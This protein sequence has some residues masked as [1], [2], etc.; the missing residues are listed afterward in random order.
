METSAEF[1]VPE[2]LQGYKALGFDMDH[3]MVNYKLDAFFEM[4][5]LMLLEGMAEQ[6]MLNESEIDFDFQ[7]EMLPYIEKYLVLDTTNGYVLKIG[8]DRKIIKVLFGQE[9]LSDERIAEVYG[10]ERQLPELCEK[11]QWPKRYVDFPSYFEA[12]FLPPMLKLIHE[13]KNNPEFHV[14]ETFSNMGKIAH[15]S[16]V[17]VLTEDLPKSRYFRYIMEEPDKYVVDHRARKEWLQK[18]REQGYKIFLVTN[19]RVGYVKLI[20]EASFGPDWDS[21]FDFV[22]LDA[23]KPEFFEKTNKA[24]KVDGEQTADVVEEGN[25]DGEQTADVVEEGNLDGEQTADV[26]EEGNLDG[27]QTADVV[28]EGNLDGEQTADVVEEGNLDGEQTADVVEEGNLELGKKYVRG[29][30]A[31]VNKA[32]GVSDRDVLFFGDQYIT[33]IAAAKQL[34]G[35]DTC[36]ICEE[37]GYLVDESKVTIPQGLG[38]KWG[39]H[40]RGEDGRE[41]FWFT[42]LRKHATHILPTI[43]TAL[44]ASTAE[45]YFKAFKAEFKDQ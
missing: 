10:E 44:D 24:H 34:A 5:I 23:R 8:P 6:Q 45:E 22:F 3:C 21:V 43:D 1:K 37:L 31:D 41:N 27:E 20:M 2:F 15:E 36:G 4:S 9:E 29:S 32:L 35:W 28:E 30:Y 26:V 7:R 38:A 40:L 11:N 12:C 19:S 17:P 39:N 33:D 18:L 13:H 42:F 16:F 14:L 25:L